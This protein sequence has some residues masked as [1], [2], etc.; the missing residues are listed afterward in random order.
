[1]YIKGYCCL[2][3]RDFSSLF[4]YWTNVTFS[5]DAVDLTIGKCFPKAKRNFQV[6]CKKT[7]YGINC[8]LMETNQAVVECS[9]CIVYNWGL[10]FVVFS[11]KTKQGKKWK[12]SGLGSFL[13]SIA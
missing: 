10:L 9:R 8:F 7:S 5:K 6:S 11:P 13:V 12:D 2:Q 1:M 4:T 3:I